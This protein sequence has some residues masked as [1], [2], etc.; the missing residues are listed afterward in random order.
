MR[1]GRVVTS[2]VAVAALHMAWPLG[3]ATARSGKSRRPQHGRVHAQPK[4][5]PTPAPA[6]AP[7]PAAPESYPAI[8]LT[9]SGDKALYKAGD[10]A[11]FSMST[12]V[13]CE[14]TLVNIGSDG[15][16][17]VLFPNDIEPDG[18]LQAG[19]TRTVPAPTA[20][21]Q[22][23]LERPG[24]EAMLAICTPPGTRPEGIVPDYDHQRFTI[25]GNW[26]AFNG[27]RAKRDGEAVAAYKELARRQPR[28][29]PPR[30]PLKPIAQPGTDGRA[31]LLLP[32]E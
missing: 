15:E 4:R 18:S 2:L 9:L 1:L 11:V 14:I 25:L 21:Y 29:A 13:A 19:Q 23:R 12:D 10:L 26:A 5:T 7:V 6:A 28:R 16:A 22:L 3:D 17:T 31:L 27:E 20:S 8:T 30:P 32:V 24:V